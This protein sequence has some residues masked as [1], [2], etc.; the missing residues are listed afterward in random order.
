MVLSARDISFH[1][2][3]G[4]VSTLRSVQYCANA[5]R[6]W[7]EH[8][9]RQPGRKMTVCLVVLRGSL[10]AAV[11]DS[12]LRVLG[13]VGWE[14]VGGRVR[15]DDIRCPCAVQVGSSSCQHWEG[16]LLPMCDIYS[17][18]L[19]LIDLPQCWRRC[20]ARERVGE[21]KRDRRGGEERVGWWGALYVQ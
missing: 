20:P 18:Y 1:V 17:F 11:G 10:Y 14:P 16:S 15:R 2:P 13:A 19:V 12:H 7:H 8:P 6:H 9:Q 5:S 3:Y 4:T 21:K